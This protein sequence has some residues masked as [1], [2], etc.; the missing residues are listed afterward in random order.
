MVKV[1]KS[2]L[3]VGFLIGALVI[4]FLSSRSMV[5]GFMQKDAGMPLDG[6]A[7]GPYDSSMGGWMATEHMPVGGLP[8]NSFQEGN[9]LMFLVGNEVK[10]ECCPAAFTTDS[11]CVCL[12]SA[13]S[14]LMAH[15]GGNK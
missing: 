14:D 6:P 5:E 3:A 7:M 2:L 13:D 4:G 10:P 12:T 8:Q 9:K 15:R 1:T 11:G